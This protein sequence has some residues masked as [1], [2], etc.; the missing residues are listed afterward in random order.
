MRPAPTASGTVGIEMPAEERDRLLGEH[1]KSSDTNQDG[2]LSRDEFT[3]FAKYLEAAATAISA[4]SAPPGDSS[5]VPTLD[6]PDVAERI[7]R[8]TLFEKF[9]V[10]NDARLDFDEVRVGLIALF[11]EMNMSTEWITDS[12]IK[13]KFASADVNNDQTLS[14]DEFQAFCDE[15]AA[16]VCHLGVACTGEAAPAPTEAAASVSSDAAAASSVAVT[17]EPEGTKG[18]CSVM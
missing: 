16:F 6:E 13:E 8:P 10:N 7:R 1:F 18:S 17:S 3:V 11:S 14:Q 5:S 15:V 4:A 12:W 9:D 2:L